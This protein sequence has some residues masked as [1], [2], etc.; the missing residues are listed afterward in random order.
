[1]LP[2]RCTLLPPAARRPITG[3]IVTVRQAR[4]WSATLLDRRTGLRQA[5]HFW[6]GVYKK[7]PER[8]NWWEKLVSVHVFACLH[9]WGRLICRHGTPTAT[10]RRRPRLPRA[11]PRQQP[12][13]RLR[14]RRGLPDLPPRLV[15]DQGAL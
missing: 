7:K 10:G 1:M 9:R 5:L 6:I 4:R 3:V 2:C 13:G 14:R 8:K 12:L 11:E 15:P